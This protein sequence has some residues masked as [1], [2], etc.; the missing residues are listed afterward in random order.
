MHRKATKEDRELVKD[1]VANGTQREK[2]MIYATSVD[3]L[4]YNV[5]QIHR[6]RK[7]MLKFMKTINDMEFKGFVTFYTAYMDYDEELLSKAYK[8][9]K[10]TCLELANDIQFL[11]KNSDLCNIANKVNKKHN[12]KEL[13]EDIVKT[14]NSDTKGKIFYLLPNGDMAYNYGNENTGL[15]HNILTRAE[16]LTEKVAMIKTHLKVK[17]DTLKHNNLCFLKTIQE[18]DTEENLNSEFYLRTLL[19]EY[20]N[21]FLQRYLPTNATEEQKALAIIPTYESIE[22]DKE[23]YEDYMDSLNKMYNKRLKELQD[24]LE[25]QRQQFLSNWD[26]G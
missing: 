1:I 21:R 3:L 12:D 5:Q 22:I 26:N 20:S 9:Y 16:G 7:T 11:G 15:W 25:Q 18:L 17:E 10:Q 23:L 8:D 4:Q 24:L 13:M 14:L 19:R 2:T 6:T